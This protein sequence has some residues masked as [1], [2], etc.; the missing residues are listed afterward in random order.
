MLKKWVIKMK[1][2]LSFSKFC[3]G[4]MSRGAILPSKHIIGEMKMGEQ[5][6]NN[7]P[8]EQDLNQ[9]LKARREKL[10]SLGINYL[11]NV[12]PDAL[13]RIPSFCQEALREAG[14]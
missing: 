2:I 4:R 11:L 14:I 3:V 12:G 6:K 7:Q 8:V 9:I 13:G 10:A 5:V 1:K